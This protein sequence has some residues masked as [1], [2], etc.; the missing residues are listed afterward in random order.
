MRASPACKARERE[1]QE[2]D[3]NARA[4]TGIWWDFWGGLGACATSGVRILP[5]HPHLHLQ[6]LCA[7]QGAAATVGAAV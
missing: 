2:R 3:G 5:P 6:A 7:G 4:N 1:R